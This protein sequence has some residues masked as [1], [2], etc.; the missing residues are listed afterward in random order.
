MT[1]EDHVKAERFYQDDGDKIKLNWFCYEYANNLYSSIK[2]SPNLNPYVASQ[3][4]AQIADFCLYYAKRMR[5]SL[6][7]KQTGKNDNIE[8]NAQYVYEYNPR[9]SRKQAQAFIEAA[10]IAWE[11]TTFMCS[12]CPC[13]CL[14]EPFELAPMFDNLAKTGWPT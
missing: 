5:R 12:V 11:E 1:M 14:L 10:Q 6:Y 7:N 13:R 2:S 9:C 8:I 4:P 3:T